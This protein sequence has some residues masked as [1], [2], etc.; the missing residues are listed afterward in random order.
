MMRALFWTSLLIA[1]SAATTWA[2]SQ[3][4]SG[5]PPPRFQS[6]DPKAGTV[7]SIPGLTPRVQVADP[8]ATQQGISGVTP[9]LESAKP[10]ATT[11]KFTPRR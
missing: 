2:Q 9:R 1:M 11:Q 4:F 6:A 7:Q 10:A 5:G 3:D 8:K